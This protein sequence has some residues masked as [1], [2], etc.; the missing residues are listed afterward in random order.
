MKVFQIRLLATLS[1]VLTTLFLQ[2]ALAQEEIESELIERT[3]TVHNSYFQLRE[4]EQYEAAY[5]MFTERQ[6]N[7]VS[8][9]EFS[10][11]WGAIREKYG[12]LTHLTNTKVTWY[13]NPEGLY[14]A[15]DFRASYE[16]LPIY[17]GFLVWSVDEDIKLQR[18]EMTF[19][20][21]HSGTL[22]TDA[23]KQEAYQRVSCN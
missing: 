3:I 20:E 23:D 11:H 21:N 6:K 2:V 15:I 4:V 1:V 14:A 16:R 8:L 10:R 17:C 19:L 5:A 9:E 22:M 13:R 12:R 18:E 7:S